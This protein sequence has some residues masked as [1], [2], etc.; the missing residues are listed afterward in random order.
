MIEATDQNFEAEV[1]KSNIPVLVDFW[2]AWCGPCQMIA[3]VVEGFAR[4]FEGRIKTVKLDV[5]ANQNAAGRFAIRSIPSLLFFKDGRM[6][7]Q[8]IGACTKAQLVS[9]AEEIL[10]G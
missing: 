8:I 9:M 5:D 7:N 10:A 1:L 6:A 2:A 4:D 3:P